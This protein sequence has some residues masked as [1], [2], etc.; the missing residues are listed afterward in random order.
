MLIGLVA[1]NA[2]LV[3]EFAKELRNQ[4]TGIIEAATT[5]ARLRLRPVLMTSFSLIIGLLPLVIASGPGSVSRQSIGTAVI[6]GLAFAT[7]T[8]IFVPVFFVIIERLREG[9]AGRGKDEAVA[10][11]T[12]SDTAVS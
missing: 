5:A 6:G 9:G 8:I 1:K 12:A 7:I 3:V 2:I 4:G 11:A 10:V